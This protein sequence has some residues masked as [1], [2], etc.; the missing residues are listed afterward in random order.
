MPFNISEFRASFLTPPA[1]TAYFTV[2]VIP[3]AIVTDVIS[4]LFNGGTTSFLASGASSA[5]IAYAL[6]LRCTSASLPGRDVNAAPLHLNGIPRINVPYAQADNPIT[7]EI[8]CSDGMVER[9]FFDYWIDRATNP[10]HPD[11]PDVL[12]KDSGRFQPA[13]YD[14]IVSS[15][16]VV[17]FTHFGIPD[18]A[19]H[20]VDAY[21][22]SITPIDFAWG[23][24]D[25]VAR[26]TVNWEY[27]HWESGAEAIMEQF[28]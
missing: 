1:K 16:Y 3:P 5:A 24:Q 21:P 25:T 9:K 22:S 10:P 7:T 6:R 12:G 18:H 11:N 14:D 8:L 2:L 23:D 20:L 19:A 15:V 28:Q 17:H 27:S 13:Y 26:F 4:N